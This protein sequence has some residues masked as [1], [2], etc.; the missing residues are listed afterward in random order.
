[1]TATWSRF[2]DRTTLRFRH[3]LSLGLVPRWGQLLRGHSMWTVAALGIQLSY[4]RTLGLR[5]IRPT[6][7]RYLLNLSF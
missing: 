4:E 6:A 3:R 7:P 1:M 2:G 5:P